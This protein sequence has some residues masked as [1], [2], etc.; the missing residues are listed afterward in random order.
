ML[1]DEL[2]CIEYHVGHSG[3]SFIKAPIKMSAFFI[4]TYRYVFILVELFVWKLIFLF[5]YD[6]Y[7]VYNFSN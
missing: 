4:L 1:A 2:V 3:S 5:F 7:Y 6:I